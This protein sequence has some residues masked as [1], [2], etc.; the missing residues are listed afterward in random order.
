MSVTRRTDH[1]GGPRTSPQPRPDLASAPPAAAPPG[2]SHKAGGGGRTGPGEGR[3]RQRRKPTAVPGGAR[4]GSQDTTISAPSRP[5][6]LQRPGRLI[7]DPEDH[8]PGPR[9][10]ELSC[11]GLLKHMVGPA[12]P[13]VIE[14]TSGDPLGLGKLWFAARHVATVA[15]YSH[16]HR[17]YL[18]ALARCPVTSQRVEECHGAGDGKPRTRSK[19]EFQAGSSQ[20]PRRPRARVPRTQ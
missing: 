3:W 7:G 11:A 14:G 18:G 10:S 13:D 5:S 16:M 19:K 9:C 8:V 1:V 15:S 6:A 2:R 17:L 4:S 12:R 20:I